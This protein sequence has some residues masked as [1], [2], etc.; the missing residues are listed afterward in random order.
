[1]IAIGCQSKR[2]RAILAA[3]ILSGML[4]SCQRYGQNQDDQLVNASGLSTNAVLALLNKGAN[5]NGHSKVTFG[6][7]PLISA[8]YHNEGDIIDLLLARGADVNV[9]DNENRTPLYWAIVRWGENT[10]LIAE[11]IQ[12]GADPHATNCF[13]ADIMDLARSQPNSRDILNILQTHST[14]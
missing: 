11:L 8:I 10:N 7:T 12:R 3:A 6:W 5:V 9:G 1:M 2:V 14:P 13:G 4:M